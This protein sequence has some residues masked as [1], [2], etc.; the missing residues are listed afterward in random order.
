MS[1]WMIA[2]SVQW[3]SPISLA[4]TRDVDLRG[5]AGD[6][7]VREDATLGVDDHAGADAAL[8]RAFALGVDLLGDVDPHD[9]GEHFA[10]DLDH[11]LGC[12]GGEGRRADGGRG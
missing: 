12:G 11:S 3:S 9:R 5:P 1:S 7:I 6:V 4:G 8:E 2:R 10:R